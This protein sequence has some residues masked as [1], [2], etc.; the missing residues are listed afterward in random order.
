MTVRDNF[1]GTNIAETN[2]GNFRSGIE[3]NNGSIRNL[4]IGNTIAFNGLTAT[5]EQVDGVQ[6]VEVGSFANQISMNSIFSNGGLGID[7]EAAD[8]VN[9]NDADDPDAGGGQSATELP[10]NIEC[11]DR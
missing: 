5:G 7:L 10:R 11:C 2:L 1:I 4:I 9:P 8:D 3:M 6:V